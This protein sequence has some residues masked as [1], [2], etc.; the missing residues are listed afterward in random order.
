M[1]FFEIFLKKSSFFVAKPAFH[2]E[3]S[4]SYSPQRTHTP[5]YICKQRNQQQKNAIDIRPH[6]T[7]HQ[8][9][10]PI[11][12]G[13]LHQAITGA[14]STPTQPSTATNPDNNHSKQNG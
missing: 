1:I 5:L 13:K 3:K 4:L 6:S 2:N 10:S 12:T 7:G 9:Q 14:N 8:Q 11:T